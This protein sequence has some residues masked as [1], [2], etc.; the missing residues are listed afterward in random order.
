M[1]QAKATILARLRYLGKKKQEHFVCLSLDSNGEVIR[2]RTVFI[3]TLTS[4]IWHPREIFAGPLKD[5]ADAV[6]I[7]HNHPSGNPTP[8]NGDIEATQRVAAAG[9]ILGIE[10][11]DHLVI[12]KNGN[13]SFLASGYLIDKPRWVNENP[14]MI[15]SHPADKKS[16]AQRD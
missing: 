4:T 3:G 6:I 11:I 13:F 10:L 5:R 15:N 2:K 8:S 12:S 1:P 9:L 14:V 16:R 7:A